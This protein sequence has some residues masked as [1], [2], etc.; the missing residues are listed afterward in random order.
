MQSFT[1]YLPWNAKMGVHAR[2]LMEFQNTCMEV[3]NVAQGFPTTW[4]R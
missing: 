1:G 2:E 4:I 3:F